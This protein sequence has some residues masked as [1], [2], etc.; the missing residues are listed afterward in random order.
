[1]KSIEVEVRYESGL[2][3]RPA[4]AF[5]RTAAR[6]ASTVRLENVTL[7][8]PAA[9]AKSI[10]AVLSAG[11]ERGHVVRIVVDGADEDRAL[12]AL[13]DLLDGLVEPVGE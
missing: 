7:G 4:A 2:H 8:R 5:V 9:D 10:V 12:G 6:F 1:V 11:V 13:R 3:A